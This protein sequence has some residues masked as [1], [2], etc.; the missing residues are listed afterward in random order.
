[1]VSS[2]EQARSV[3]AAAGLRPQAVA[4]TALAILAGLVVLDL[5]AIFLTDGGTGPGRQVGNLFFL[6]RESNLPTLFNYSLLIGIAALLAL[7]AARAF[8]G[9][10]AGGITG[11]G[12]RSSS[13]SSPTTRRR[14]C[15]S[16]WCRSSGKSWKRRASSISAG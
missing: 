12:W 2:I 3:P 6:D 1:M 8:N 13:W 15:T 16:G 4:G 5:V 10:A 7:L 11:Q 14:R 9:G